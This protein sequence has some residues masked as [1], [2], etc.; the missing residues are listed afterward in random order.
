MTMANLTSQENPAYQQWIAMDQTLL[1][2]V[3]AT[4]SLFTLSLAVGNNTTQGVWEEL[5]HAYRNQ[6][7]TNQIIMHSAML[8]EHAMNLYH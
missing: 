2:L 4:L 8:C 5:L 3:N 7:L 6:R 1:T